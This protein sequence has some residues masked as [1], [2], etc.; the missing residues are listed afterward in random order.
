MMLSIVS[1]SNEIS[2]MESGDPKKYYNKTF[3][4]MKKII[5]ICSPKPLKYH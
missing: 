2:K 1:K 5:Y 4:V 3:N